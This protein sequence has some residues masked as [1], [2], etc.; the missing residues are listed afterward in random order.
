MIPDCVWGVVDCVGE[1]LTVAVE[2]GVEIVG[3]GLA[4]VVYVDMGDDGVDDGVDATQPLARTRAIMVKIRIVGI[5]PKRAS[6]TQGQRVLLSIV[7]LFSGVFLNAAAAATNFL[8]NASV[9]YAWVYA[10]MVEYS[11][12][13]SLPC[14]MPAPFPSRI[15]KRAS[16]SHS[17]FE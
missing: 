5:L 15:A 13:P 10:P 9:K 6:A 3:D 11:V 8:Q 17:T 2:Q 1:Y 14:P 7:H 4:V 16:G 12:I